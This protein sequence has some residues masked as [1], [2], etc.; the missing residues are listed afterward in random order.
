MK[1]DG[2]F[3]GISAVIFDM[4]GTLIDSMWV[5]RDIDNEFLD[6]H[7]FKNDFLHEDGIEGMSFDETAVYFKD[8]YGLSESID[9]IKA[10]WNEMA[11]ERYA[12]KVPFKSGVKEFLES[13]LK[14]NIIMGIATSNSRALV[15]ATGKRLDF[16][17]YFSSIV[18]SDEI[19]AG[20]PAPDV[21]LK[22][23]GHLKTEPENCL[24]FEDLCQGIRAGKAAGMR[25]C[26]VADAY[27]ANSEDM[28]RQLADYFINDYHELL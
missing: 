28:K 17:R 24:V 4:D 12:Q 1:L 14:N 15:E 5:W 7:G 11:F 16:G 19:T 27:S 20:K 22:A 9:E 21:Y 8:Y 13:C 10:K 23:A 2:I 6:T 26:A 3:D 25:V 18:T